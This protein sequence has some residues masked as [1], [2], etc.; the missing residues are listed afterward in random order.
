MEHMW[1]DTKRENPKYLLGT[2]PVPVQFSHQK[3][4]TNRPGQEIGILC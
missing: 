3:H 1:N 4:H 2:K